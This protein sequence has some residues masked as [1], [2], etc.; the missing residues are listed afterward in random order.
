MSKDISA[1]FFSQE[2]FLEAGC[3]NMTA[4][5]DTVHKALCDHER[6]RVLFPEKTVQIFRDSPQ[7]RINCLPA[8]LLDEEVCG[9][10]WVSVFNDNPAA[11]NRQAITAV[12]V[13]SEI[14]TGFPLYVM[15][16]TF[17]S[18]MRVAAVGGAGAR[19]FARKDSRVIGFLGAGE[20]AK[21]H[22]LGMRAALPSLEECRVC[23]AGPAEEDRF[24]GQMRAILPDMR[25]A[26]GR[27]DLR[28]TLEGAD[29]VVTAT[30]LQQ[31]LVTASMVGKGSYL[32]QIGPYETTADLVLQSDKIVCDSWEAILHRGSQP[33]T[34]LHRQGL[35]PAG[36]VT[37]IAQVASGRKP[38]R[39]NADERIYF[40]HVGL[41]YLDL[42]IGLQFAR[43]AERA[44]LGKK[45]ALQ[46]TPLFEHES[47]RSRITL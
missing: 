30:P 13:I 33:L 11:H 25:F 36:A 29:V 26:A 28:R 16:G 23:A 10:K 21:S 38:G 3:L 31:P 42:A 27:G 34:L 12:M 47:I 44:G 5:I 40:K 35:L 32:S 6:G 15:D 37:E 45:L 18:T 17:C 9:M 43:A 2:D 24:I 39:E 8:T 20:Q 46:K 41:S 4:A 14:R 19:Y 22:L 7:D 1:I